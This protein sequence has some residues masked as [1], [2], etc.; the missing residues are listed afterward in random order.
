M[1]DGFVSQE[2]VDDCSETDCYLSS[3]RK[4]LYISYA[5]GSRFQLTKLQKA[6][7]QPWYSG[8]R[9]SCACRWRVH[10]IEVS[11]HKSVVFYHVHGS[12]FQFP[13][14]VRRCSISFI[15]TYL[16]KLDGW[17]WKAGEFATKS[18]ES[19]VCQSH[20]ALLRNLPKY[21][22]RAYYRFERIYY[23]V[24]I[25]SRRH[26]SKVSTEDYSISHIKGLVKGPVGKVDWVTLSLAHFVDEYSYAVFNRF[27]E[28]LRSP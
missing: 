12:L 6:R 10:D 1:V 25:P 8:V 18:H 19:F 24:E 21:S 13:V 22:S 2:T 4:A 14:Q 20:R 27:C 28:Y 17:I 11:H 15:Y 9:L 3:G 26:I 7:L 5:E 16:K 23:L